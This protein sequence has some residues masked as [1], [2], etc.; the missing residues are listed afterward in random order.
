MTEANII[1]EEIETLI[2]DFQHQYNERPR[3]V[4]VPLWVKRI[5]ID[6][7]KELL[8]NFNYKELEELEETE[9]FKVYGLKICET[10]K[11]NNI[12]E[13]EVF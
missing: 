7:A 5:L 3:Y 13:I 2:T 9:N 12:G 4:K 10:I 6:Y 8:T 1:L 11:I